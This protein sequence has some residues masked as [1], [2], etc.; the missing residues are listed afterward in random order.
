ML[1]TERLLSRP[2]APEDAEAIYERVY[3]DPEVR[4][5]WSAYRG[6]LVDFRERFGTGRLWLGTPDGFGYR[7]LVRKADRE[8]LGLMGFQNHA[9][10]DMDWLLMPDGSRNVGHIPGVV[11]AELTYALG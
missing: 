8:L 4:D 11:D 1:E 3:A 10:D 5:H 9:E 6:T 7:A 2:F